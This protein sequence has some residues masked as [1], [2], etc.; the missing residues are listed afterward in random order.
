M[1]TT[2]GMM[3]GLTTVVLGAMERRKVRKSSVDEVRNVGVSHLVSSVG[4]GMQNSW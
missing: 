1:G 3:E 2:E 4:C